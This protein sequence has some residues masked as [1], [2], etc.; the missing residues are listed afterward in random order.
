MLTVTRMPVAIQI[1]VGV[2]LPK[3]TLQERQRP[4]VDLLA[5]LLHPAKVRPVGGVLHGDS[6]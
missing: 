3:L 2:R 4:L 1:G 6:P 5:Q